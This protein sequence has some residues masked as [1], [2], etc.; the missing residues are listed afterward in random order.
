VAPVT[1]ELASTATNTGDNRPG[2]TLGLGSWPR[3]DDGR[4]MSS[5]ADGLAAMDVWYGGA[6]RYRRLGKTGLGNWLRDVD[7][8]RWDF[9]PMYFKY[10]RLGELVRRVDS[11]EQLLDGEA[12]TV[13]EP[14][15]R[16]Y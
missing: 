16:Y 8:S 6:M 14:G 5:A 9:R 13:P 12:S 10:E 4:H 1:H 15:P 3:P 2:G 11:L 7:D